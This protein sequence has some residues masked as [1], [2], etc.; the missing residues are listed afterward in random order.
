MQEELQQVLKQNLKD[1]HLPPEVGL[2]P[3]APGW[4]V[5]LVLILG[6]LMVTIHKLRQYR[7]KNRYR[8]TA[9]KLLNQSYIEWQDQNNTSQYLQTAN[10]LLRRSVMHATNNGDQTPFND[11]LNASIG[12]TGKTWIEI[13]NSLSKQNLTEVTESALTVKIYQQNPNVDIEQVHQELNAW[14]N[15]HKSLKVDQ[16]TNQL[17]VQRSDV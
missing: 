1:I 8:K 15:K 7:A 12:A 5:L 4:W 13:L 9:A 3:L 17:P 2:W 10:S 16:S 6:M 11:K 14:I